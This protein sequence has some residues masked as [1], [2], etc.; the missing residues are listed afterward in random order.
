MLCNFI[1]NVQSE[2]M[3][4]AVQSLRSLIRCLVESLVE[5]LLLVLLRDTNTTVD[6]F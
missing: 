2:A 4:V 5:K 1:A 6:H 3:A